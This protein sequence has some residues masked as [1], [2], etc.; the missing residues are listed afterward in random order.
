[1]AGGV[2]RHSELFQVLLVCCQA[3][4]V[5]RAVIEG[6]EK[7]G[8]Q[9]RRKCRGVLR[10]EASG[11]MLGGETSDAL[12]PAHLF[13]NWKRDDYFKLGDFSYVS[14]TAV[15]YILFDYFCLLWWQ[16]LA[17]EEICVA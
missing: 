13:I 9:R 6:P 15:V 1:M 4:R 17:D 5:V 10:R 2:G 11:W 14:R 16:R 12:N 8:E 7:L 3:G